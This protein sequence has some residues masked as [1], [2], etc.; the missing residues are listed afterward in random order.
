MRVLSRWSGLRPCDLR[1]AA[2]A[3]LGS[4]GRPFCLPTPAAHRCST[5]FGWSAAAVCAARG[6]FSRETAF[7][8]E[9]ICLGSAHWGVS[10]GTPARRTLQGALIPFNAAQRAKVR[11]PGGQT[12]RDGAS[13]ALLRCFRSIRLAQPHGRRRNGH[14][15]PRT[16]ASSAWRRPETTGDDRGR[17]GTTHGAAFRISGFRLP[18]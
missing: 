17:P 4:P 5:R 2:D 8:L 16:L 13:V 11:P 10:H 7:S 3:R 12:H 18:C 9:A 6:T 14:S 1:I 15:C